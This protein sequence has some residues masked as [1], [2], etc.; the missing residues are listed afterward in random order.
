MHHLPSLRATY[1]K[2]KGSFDILLHRKWKNVINA[3]LHTVLNSE[4]SIPT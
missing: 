3:K 1:T 2:V 4:L